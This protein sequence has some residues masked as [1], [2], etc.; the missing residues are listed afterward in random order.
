MGDANCEAVILLAYGQTAESGD[1]HDSHDS[2]PTVLT[3]DPV[4]PARKA[5]PQR[6]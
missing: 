6:K 1:S 2:D 5:G 4:N 3:G